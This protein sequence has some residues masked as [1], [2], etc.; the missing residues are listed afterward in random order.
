MAMVLLGGRN[1]EVVNDLQYDD[2]KLYPATISLL[3]IYIDT[4]EILN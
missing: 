1:A 4:E 3:I 2:S